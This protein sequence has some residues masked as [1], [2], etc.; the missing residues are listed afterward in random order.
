MP[1]FDYDN[2]EDVAWIKT[3]NHLWGMRL[4]ARGELSVNE[5][6]AEA[7][8][9]LMELRTRLQS[10][11]IHAFMLT[12]GSYLFVRNFVLSTKS[13][14]TCYRSLPV[15]CCFIGA[16]LGMVFCIQSIMFVFSIHM[17]CRILLLTAWYGLSISQICNNVILLQKAYLVMY[18]QRWM[19]IIAI[20]L[21]LPTALCGLLIT[22]TSFITLDR[23]GSCG[24]HYPAF[25]PIYWFG[26][27]ASVNL[28]FSIIFCRVAYKQYR[29]FGSDAWRR[30]AR[31]GIQTMCMVTLCNIV[32]CTLVMLK[33]GGNFADVFFPLDWYVHL[34]NRATTM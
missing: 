30:L 23:V 8:D 34:I 10:I 32:S 21:M 33:A 29:L 15:W 27:I 18:Q 3:T 14:F 19:L 28:M 25:L 17:N 26:A 31:D 2:P 16:V 20:P 11:L 12:I 1:A 5:F 13:L 7:E 24:T 9:D 22:F 6:Y 4:H